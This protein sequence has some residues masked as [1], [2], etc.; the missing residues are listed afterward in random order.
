MSHLILQLIKIIKINY[1]SQY[2]GSINGINLPIEFNNEIIGVIGI[3]GDPKEVEQ[4]G[5][6][7]KK[8]TEILIKEEWIIQNKVNKKE[9]YKNII[10]AF[11]QNKTENISLF[12]NANRKTKKLIAVSEIEEYNFS[13][14]SSNDIF[15]TIDSYFNDSDDTFYTILYNELIMVCQHFFGQFNIE[16]FC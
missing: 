11:I 2:K 9:Y 4:Y 3:T 16:H 14:S 10:E 12:N 13:T 5:L 1:N 15:S 8:M 6:I 7:T